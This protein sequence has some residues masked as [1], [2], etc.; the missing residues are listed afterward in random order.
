MPGKVYRSV[1][2]PYVDFIRKQRM[3]RATWR[4]IAEAITAQGTP[5]S[6]QCVHAFF[7]RHER[8]FHPLGFPEKIEPDATKLRRDNEPAPK[9]VWDARQRGYDEVNEVVA[10][11]GK[12]EQARPALADVISFPVP[13]VEKRETGWE[14]FKKAIE[15][16]DRKYE[17]E[18][19][20][21][22]GA[23]LCRPT[24]KEACEG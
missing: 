18:R 12:V 6:R 1:L 9:T 10:E 15:E 3:A 5:T 2:L 21:R 20:A 14:S 24:P 22:L 4:E 17:E 23:N 19:K 11:L 13:K 16:R 8:Q 7:K